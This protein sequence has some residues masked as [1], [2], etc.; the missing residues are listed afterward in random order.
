M[1]MIF[2]QMK[3]SD[4]ILN[5][6]KT[7]FLVPKDQINECW[8]WIGRTHYK[9]GQFDLEFNNIKIIAAHRFMYELYY[10]PIPSGL[11][12]MHK[13]DNCLCVNPYHLKADTQ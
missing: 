12:V 13:C 5:R 3:Y 6:F 4:S 1:D 2:N 11:V 8:I 9:Y 7:K 10:G